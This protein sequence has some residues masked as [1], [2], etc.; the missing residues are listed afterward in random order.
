MTKTTEPTTRRQGAAAIARVTRSDSADCRCRHC[1]WRF[2]DGRD[3][4]DHVAA[5]GHVVQV[6]RVHR[7]DLVPRRMNHKAVCDG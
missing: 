3:A 1:G 6:R 7:F 2:D 5:T 4:L